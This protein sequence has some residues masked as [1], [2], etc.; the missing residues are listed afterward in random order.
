MRSCPLPRQALKLY[1]HAK[2][3]TAGRAAPG[4]AGQ[5]PVL[6]RGSVSY[7]TCLQACNDGEPMYAHAG[8][9]GSATGIL[10]DLEERGLLD[11]SV[12]AAR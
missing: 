10:R 9:V 6:P 7:C 11:V 12:C 5:A 3:W 2:G 8:I 1:W 4:S